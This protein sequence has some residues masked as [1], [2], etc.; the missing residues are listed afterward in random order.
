VTGEHEIGPVAERHRFD[1]AALERYLCAHLAGFEGPW[2]LKQFEGGQ[3]NPTFLISSPSGEYVLRKQPPGRL[4]SSA[5]AVDR[6]YRIMKALADT[7]VPAPRVQLYCPDAS[8]IGTPFYVMHFLAGRVHRDPLLPGVEP[9]D[10]AAMYDAMNETLAA[11]HSVDW[12]SAGLADYGKTR[13]YVARQLARWSKQYKAAKTV[14]DPLMEKVM[15]WLGAN[16]PASESVTIAHGDYRLENL[17]FHPRE[18]RVIGVLDWELSTLGNPIGDLAFNCMT[19]HIPASDIL[20]GSFVGADIAA[21]GIPSEADYVEAYCRRTDRDAIPEWRFFLISSLFRTA[22]IMQGVYA[23]ALQ[24][25][26]SSVQARLFG[27]LAGVAAEAAWALA[28]G[29]NEGGL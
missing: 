9:A 12:D 25:N 21:L 11:L 26:A 10:R 1:E 19:Y 16:M 29:R 20:P 27:D 7:D 22:A 6:E 14:D 8:I 4:L 23:R 3:S 5:H 24:G 13:N 17:V 28:E 15:E 18:P 2:T